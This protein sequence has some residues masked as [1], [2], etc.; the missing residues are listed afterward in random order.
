[1]TRLEQIKSLQRQC[2]SQLARAHIAGDQP[3]MRELSQLRERL[4]KMAE[5]YCACGQ[6]KNRG[7]VRCRV[8]NQAARGNAPHSRNRKRRIK[9]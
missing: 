7:T 6:A 2:R 4:K 1:M 9:S 5:K 8:C 3:L